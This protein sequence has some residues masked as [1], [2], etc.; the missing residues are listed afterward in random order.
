MSRHTFAKSARASRAHVRRI[1]CTCTAGRSSV[2]SQA[3]STAQPP[4]SAEQQAAAQRDPIRL[5]TIART[6][7]RASTVSQPSTTS[8]AI[9]TAQIPKKRSC[10]G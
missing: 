3:S 2:V 4:S 8:P 7:K 6:E 10:V 9:L 1:L 5:W